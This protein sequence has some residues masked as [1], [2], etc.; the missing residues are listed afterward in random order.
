MTA[1]KLKQY[2]LIN[3][4]NYILSMN[5]AL[6]ITS[7]IFKVKFFFLQKIPIIKY[8]ISKETILEIELIQIF[9]LNQS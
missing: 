9:K 7:T 4:I 3:S 6:R 2:V 5:I 1:E 8:K